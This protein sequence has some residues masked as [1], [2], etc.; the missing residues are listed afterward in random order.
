[1]HGP[2]HHHLYGGSYSDA[3]LM[4]WADRIREWHAAGQDV[5]A[6]FNNAGTDPRR[7]RDTAGPAPRHPAVYLLGGRGRPAGLYTVG[8]LEA[9]DRTGRY[10]RLED[11][12]AAGRS[13][14]Q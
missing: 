6:Y 12:L 9:R 8:L 1:M 5:F 7:V 11:W 10:F 3:D 2:D 14:S 13:G 4:W